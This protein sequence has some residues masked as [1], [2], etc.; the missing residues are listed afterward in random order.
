M[1]V[2]KQMRAAQD[3]AEVMRRMRAMLETFRNDK[4]EDLALPARALMISRRLH[5]MKAVLNAAASVGI[6][7]DNETQQRVYGKEL[8]HG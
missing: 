5:E 8:P 4:P 1:M 7:A 6:E 2:D 3:L